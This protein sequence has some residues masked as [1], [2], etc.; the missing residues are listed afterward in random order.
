MAKRH[1]AFCKIYIQEG[2]HWEFPGGLSTFT[3]QG[4]GSVPGQGA[5]TLQAAQHNQK[6]KKERVKKG[7]TKSLFRWGFLPSLLPFFLLP[8]FSLLRQQG[9]HEGPL[10]SS[11]CKWA[12]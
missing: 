2:S 9:V 5:K 12:Q 1:C 3:V 6:K 7:A 4:L 11:V 10:G 8:S